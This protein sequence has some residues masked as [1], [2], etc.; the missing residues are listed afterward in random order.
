M[1]SQIHCYLSTN[2]KDLR[3]LEKLHPRLVAKAKERWYVPDPNKASDLEKMRL[4]EL[5][6]EFETYHQATTKKIKEFRIEAIR[7]GFKQA[8]SDKA[9]RT[10]ADVA[11]K[12]PDSVIEEDEQLLLY[13]D[14]ALNRLG[15]D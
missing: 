1:P 9:Y 10:I 6:K 12:L 5:L 4:R 3:N 7:A 11:K 15:E 14:N 2:Y 8:W 13:H